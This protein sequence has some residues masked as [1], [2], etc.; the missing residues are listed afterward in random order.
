MHTY[1]THAHLDHL[2]NLEEALE[3]ARREGIRGIVAM[4]MDLKSCR[5]NLEIKRAV[6]SPEIYLGMG[7]HPSEANLADLDE[8]LKLAR[9]NVKELTVIGEIGLD[10]W[11]KW[12]RKDEQKKDEQRKVFRSFLELAKELNLPVAIHSRGAWRECLETVVQVG[13]SKAEFHW[14]SGPVD[15][16]HDII[17]AGFYV[18]ASPSL[19]YSAQLREAI[20]HAPMERVLIETDSPVYFGN[21]DEGNGF[22]AQPKDV[23]KTLE[24][25][26]ELMNCNK[27][28]TL[29]VFNKNAE[30]FFGLIGSLKF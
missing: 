18:S 25:Y 5:R 15:V 4:S 28:Q 6:S 8:C 23:F 22:E 10:F 24:A 1:D 30:D 26:C 20:R 9:N 27:E 21:R 7:M 16:L 11:Y 3:G 17:A 29:A 2:P 13:L 19:A 12:V 14:Y